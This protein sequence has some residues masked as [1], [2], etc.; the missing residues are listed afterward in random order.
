MAQ[1]RSQQISTGYMDGKLSP[2]LERLGL[3][4]KNWFT[5]STKF[6]TEFTTFVG[7][8]DSIE[9]ACKALSKSG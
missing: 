9:L 4:K 2:I 7:K 6:E 8:K 5:A 1:P 3:S